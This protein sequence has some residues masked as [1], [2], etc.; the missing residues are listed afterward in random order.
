MLPSQIPPATNPPRW[1]TT[2][3]AAAARWIYYSKCPSSRLGSLETV[4]IPLRSSSSTSI[5]GRSPVVMPLSSSDPATIKRGCLADKISVATSAAP[6]MTPPLQGFA[7]PVARDKTAPGSQRQFG[8]ASSATDG[9]S[10][11]ATITITMSYLFT[12][13]PNLP[14]ARRPELRSRS[15]RSARCSRQR[16]L[17]PAISPRLYVKSTPAKYIPLLRYY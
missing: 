16:L 10:R 8:E 2:A 1:L 12:L 14:I 5:S 7:R 17:D 15:K 4:S 11:S 6:I 3:A 13:L 9:F